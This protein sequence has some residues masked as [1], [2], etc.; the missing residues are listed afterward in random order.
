MTFIHWLNFR[1]DIVLIEWRIFNSAPYVWGFCYIV[2][3]FLRGKFAEKT[4]F[5]RFWNNDFLFDDAVVKDLNISDD[6]LSNDIIDVVLNLNDWCDWMMNFFW[7]VNRTNDLMFLFI[8]R[9]LYNEI[10]TLFRLMFFITCYL[11]NKFIQKYDS[12]T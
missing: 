6:D 5:E 1:E 10:V 4:G 12:S 9:S 8:P 7:F 3:D 2:V 11:Y